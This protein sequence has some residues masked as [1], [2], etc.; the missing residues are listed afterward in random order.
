M[1]LQLGLGRVSDVHL[2]SDS[3]EV[4]CGGAVCGLQSVQLVVGNTSMGVS[5]YYNATAP[6][7]TPVRTLRRLRSW[8]SE[9]LD[10]G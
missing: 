9:T 6:H 7:N 1:G 8:R 5:K 4:H 10:A 3:R 2:C